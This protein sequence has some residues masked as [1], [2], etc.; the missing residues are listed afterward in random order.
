M[1]SFLVRRLKPA[2]FICHMPACRQAG[3][4]QMIIG[5]ACLLKRQGYMPVRGDFI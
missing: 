1:C 4:P 2:F 5:A 3:N